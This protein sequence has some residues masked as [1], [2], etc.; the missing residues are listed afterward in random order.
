MMPISVT[1]FWYILFQT[2][3]HTHMLSFVVAVIVVFV[4]LLHTILEQCR[5]QEY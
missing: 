2:L 3:K 4:L 1:V 5:G